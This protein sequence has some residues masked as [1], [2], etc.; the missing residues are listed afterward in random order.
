MFI[1]M[2]QANMNGVN[3]GSSSNSISAQNNQIG[4]NNLADSGFITI[5]T[6]LIGISNTLISTDSCLFASAG[7][8]NTDCNGL[9]KGLSVESGGGEVAD[10]NIMNAIQ[11]IMAFMM[12]GQALIQQPFVVGNNS[13]QSSELTDNMVMQPHNGNTAVEWMLKSED[14]M[15]NIKIHANNNGNYLLQI[16]EAAEAEILQLSELQG[17][18]SSAFEGQDAALKDNI[19]KIIG[20]PEENPVT[21]KAPEQLKQFKVVMPLPNAGQGDNDLKIHIKTSIGASDGRKDIDAGGKSFPSN[22][23][24]SEIPAAVQHFQ[25]ATNIKNENIVKETLHVNRLNEISES[26]MKTLSAGDKHLIIKLEPPDLGSI[27]IK[28]RMD[29]GMLRADLKV[30][31]PAVKELF[32]MA[33]PQIRASLGDAGIKVGD[34]FVDVKEDYYSD[35]RRHQDGGGGQ[36]HRQ[37][38]EQKFR[39]FDYFA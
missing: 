30:E 15:R 28:L 8:Q 17:F 29:N 5:F 25:E 6:L 19:P 10:E 26:I 14:G 31:S 12:G 38:K 23:G 9:L 16:K 32:S 1:N 35:G 13:R 24:H 22:N 11:Q 7:C 2:I 27:Q 21:D 34:F 4:Q 37:N 39:F 33:M 20:L 36:Q 18:K 3:G